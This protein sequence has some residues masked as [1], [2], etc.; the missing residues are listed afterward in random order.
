MKQS[1]EKRSPGVYQHKLKV[2]WLV[3]RGGKVR[4]FKIGEATQHQVV[5]KL[6]RFA[7]GDTILP[8]GG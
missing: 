6:H 3:E 5:P 4:P 8:T 2:L 1:G 7:H